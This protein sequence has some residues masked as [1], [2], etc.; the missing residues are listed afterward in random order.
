MLKLI[1]QCKHKPTASEDFTHWFFY[2]ANS[3]N[4]KVNEVVPEDQLVIN[5]FPEISEEEID[6]LIELAKSH[7]YKLPVRECEFTPQQLELR[8]NVSSCM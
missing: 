6:E 4:I 5:K 3:E 7:V 1:P 2:R 8:K